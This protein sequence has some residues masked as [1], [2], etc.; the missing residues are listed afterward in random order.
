MGEA[1][2]GEFRAVPKNP[3]T[4][5]MTNRSRPTICCSSG[6]HRGHSESV[7]AAIDTLDRNSLPD[8]ELEF[9]GKN[10]LQFGGAALGFAAQ[11]ACKIWR[12]GS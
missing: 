3:R 8:K 2:G 12:V 7:A 4:K 11:R 9:F 6:R 5:T 10:I 1:F